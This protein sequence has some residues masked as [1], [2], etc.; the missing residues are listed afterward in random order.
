MSILLLPFITF[1]LI[2]LQPIIVSGQS[3]LPLENDISLNNRPIIGKYRFHYLYIRVHIYVN[4]FYRYQILKGKG[5]ERVD[6]EYKIL[7][8]GNK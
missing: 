5:E 7:L 1:T 6:T 3:S 8:V 4:I 2:V